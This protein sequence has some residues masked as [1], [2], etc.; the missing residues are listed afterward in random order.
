M[1]DKYVRFSGSQLYTEFNCGRG[2]TLQGQIEIHAVKEAG[3]DTVLKV[4][5]GLAIIQ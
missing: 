5:S 3:K 1:T 4:V 2:C